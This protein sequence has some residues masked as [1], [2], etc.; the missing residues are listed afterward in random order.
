[1]LRESLQQAGDA[2]LPKQGVAL[3]L[4]S[5]YIMASLGVLSTTYR[6]GTWQ[7]LRQSLGVEN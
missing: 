1:M 3:L 6:Q 7:L 2:L 4:D 5:Y